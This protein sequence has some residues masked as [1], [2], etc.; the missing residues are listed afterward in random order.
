MKEIYDEA[1]GA[2][3][4]KEDESDPLEKRVKI[5]E[6]KVN[7][8]EKKLDTVYRELQAVMRHLA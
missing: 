7:Y 3:L 5:L 2:I 8:L 1:T 6:D 4:Y